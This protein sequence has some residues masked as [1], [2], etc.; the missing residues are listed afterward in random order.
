MGSRLGM[1]ERF[2]R[3]V[4]YRRL[5]IASIV[6]S[7]IFVGLMVSAFLAGKPQPVTFVLGFTH[8]VLFMVMAAVC[9]VA[10]RYRML[11]PEV[12]VAVVAF[13]AVGPML[14]SAWFVR[15]SRRWAETG[16]RSYRNAEA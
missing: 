6:H 5:E 4:T 16:G 1:E 12:V 15:Y 7:V 10:A 3:I 14:G 8:G 13:G 2:R 9:I 11:P